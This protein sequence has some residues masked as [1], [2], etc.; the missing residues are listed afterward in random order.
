ML[1]QFYLTLIGFSSTVVPNSLI[2]NSF[3][4]DK[5]YN[6]EFSSVLKALF[7]QISIFKKLFCF[8][9]LLSTILIPL[10][11]KIIFITILT[12]LAQGID[13]P[14][15]NKTNLSQ[16]SLIYPRN[17]SCS[18]LFLMSYCIARIIPPLF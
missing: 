17:S 2:K 14:S 7:I 5:G 10:I 13:S 12:K 3:K 15:S 11:Y 8:G 16:K 18:L 4:L 6:L 1:L 9:L